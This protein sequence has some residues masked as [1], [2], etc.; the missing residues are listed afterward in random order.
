MLE[1]TRRE[2]NEL[3][4]FFHLLGHGVIAMGDA[5]GKAGASIPV[6]YVQ[7]QEH[8][9]VRRYVI[10]PEEIS[11]E[12]EKVRMS[13]PREDFRAASEWL[14][15]RHRES[16]GQT[17]IDITDIEGFLDA[18]QIFDME[19]QTDDRTDLHLG[20]Y[21]M[22]GPV[23]GVR[24]QSLMCGYM[25]LLSGGRQ[26]NIKFEQS[27]IKLS[28]PAVSK[29]NYT[30]Q[31]ENVAEVARRMLYI[32]SIGGVLK[33][34]DV[35]DRVFKSNLLMIDTNLPRIIGTM[36][37][38]LHLDGI[39][40]VKDLVADL[41]ERNPLKVKDELVRKHGFY[42]HKVRQLLLAAAWG[43]RPAKQWNGR[44]SAVN[45]YIMV[46]AQGRMVLYSRMDEQTFSDFLFAH[47]RLDRT[48]PEEDKYGY[49][50]RENGVY[51]LKLNL[52]ISLTK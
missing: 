24:I 31:P 14:L 27:G 25:P 8:D 5:E 17:E 22:D 3:Y 21:T 49:L 50:E 52:R 18:L 20:L 28:Q 12:G 42:E 47:T 19:A 51:Y 30:E 48:L 33:F 1:A 37:R 34:A 15:E 9:G 10:G 6:A 43:M 29:I 41:S 40:R 38:T 36:L 44:Q 35:A 11:V 7:R 23:V 2:L 26:A 45:G 4:V 39:N 32:E 46:D 13:L 16:Q